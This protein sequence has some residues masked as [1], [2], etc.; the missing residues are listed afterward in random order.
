MG[1]WLHL[2][3][4]PQTVSLH[5]RAEL[6]QHAQRVSPGHRIPTFREIR[7][8]RRRA[9]LLYDPAARSVGNRRPRGAD[10]PVPACQPGMRRDEPARL[11]AETPPTQPIL[12]I[13]EVHPK[14]DGDGTM[15]GSVADSGAASAASIRA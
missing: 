10:R 14:A 2:S 6:R 4:L 13:R 1:F 7:L 12:T 11:A 8:D 15:D 9:R 5:R 3:R